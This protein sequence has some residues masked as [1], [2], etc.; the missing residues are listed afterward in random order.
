MLKLGFHVREADPCRFFPGITKVD[1]VEEPV[2]AI[3]EARHDPKIIIEAGIVG[4][5]IECAV[6]M[7]TTAR[8]R[9][10][11]PGE[12]E[13]VGSGPWLLRL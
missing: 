12:I 3:E 9:A 5:E 13:V 1:S 8:C 10:S 2:P 6:L 4:R 11:H 7:A